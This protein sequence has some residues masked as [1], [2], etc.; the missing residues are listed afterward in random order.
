MTKLMKSQITNKIQK[1]K[2]LI[3]MIISQILN[4]CQLETAK[5]NQEFL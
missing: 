2:K 5:L 4:R 3:N 1:N